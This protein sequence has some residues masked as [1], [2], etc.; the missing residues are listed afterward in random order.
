MIQI[1]WC[2]FIRLFCINGEKKTLFLFNASMYFYLL[3]KVD[4]VQQSVHNKPQIIIWYLANDIRLL[5]LQPLRFL[6]H[7]QIAALAICV[8]VNESVFGLRLFPSTILITFAVCPFI[9]VAV[10]ASLMDMKAQS[11]D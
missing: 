6:K 9:T 3:S 5:I 4:G 1:K 7:L 10:K 11:I 2:Q 8:F